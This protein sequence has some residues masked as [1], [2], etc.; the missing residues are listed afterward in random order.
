MHTQF[1]VFKQ[2]ILI[3]F[4]TKFS[5]IC[6]EQKGDTQTRWHRTKWSEQPGIHK[7]GPGANTDRDII[8]YRSLNRVV[9]R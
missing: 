9:T 8:S 6:L 3:S 4:H 2:V 1:D 7:R 5:F